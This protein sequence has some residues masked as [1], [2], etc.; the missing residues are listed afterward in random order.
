VAPRTQRFCELGAREQIEALG[1]ASSM[2]YFAD[3]WVWYRAGLENENLWGTEA[4]GGANFSAPSVNR[5]RR[6]VEYDDLSQQHRVGHVGRY[7]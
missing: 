7:R 5:Q 4:N 1:V 2:F 3:R 6:N